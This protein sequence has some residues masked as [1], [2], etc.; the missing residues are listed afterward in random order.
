ML[1]GAALRDPIG[2]RTSRFFPGAVTREGTYG[3]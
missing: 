3:K 1:A 2:Y